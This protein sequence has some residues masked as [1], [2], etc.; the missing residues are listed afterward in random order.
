MGA[1]SKAAVEALGNSLRVELADCGVDVGV[2]H[3]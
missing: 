1:G 3:P 2:F